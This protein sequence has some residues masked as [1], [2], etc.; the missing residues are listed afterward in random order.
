MDAEKRYGFPHTGTSLSCGKYKDASARATAQS[1]AET[2]HTAFSMSLTVI[3]SFSS[4]QIWL[5]PM[6]QAWAEAVIRSS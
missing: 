2:T 3:C 5:P 6:E 4:S 1:L